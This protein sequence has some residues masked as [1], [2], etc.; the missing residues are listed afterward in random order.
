MKPFSI[1]IL[2][3]FLTTISFART[4]TQE[5]TLKI[6]GESFSV[7]LA[8]DGG[9][10][11]VLSSNDAQECRVS[12]HY[13]EDKCSV[14][15]R[16]NEKRGQLD[17]SIDYEKWD[18]DENDAP[19]LIVELPFKPKISLSSHIKAGETQFDLGGLTITDFRMRHW[20][21]ETEIDFEEPNR[22]VMSTFDV[23]VKIG[24]M[25]I[26]NLGNARFEEGEIDGGIGEMTV[27]FRGSVMNKCVARIDLDI[28]ETTLIIPE[29]VGSKLRVS[30]FLFLSEMDYPEWFTRRGDFYYSQNYEDSEEQLYL[31]IS[32]GIGELKVKIE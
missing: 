1:V 12:L 24:E 5:E 4:K 26:R 32:S 13:P 23:N 15:L 8:V 28:G 14:D 6:E 30:H 25:T 20:A 22:T 17:I 2:I 7:D 16:Y 10:V 11:Q 18:M 19:N 31:M 21:G 27:D 3:M 29:K 9:K